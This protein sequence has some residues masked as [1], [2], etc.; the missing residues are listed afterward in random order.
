M[1]TI[2]EFEND[3]TECGSLVSGIA[4]SG[5]IEFISDATVYSTSRSINWI[6]L[7][8][9]LWKSNTT[10]MLNSYHFYDNLVAAIGKTPP[11]SYFIDVLVCT[12]G[13]I[14]TLFALSYSK[15]IDKRV[16]AC[17][18]LPEIEQK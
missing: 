11:S 8:L 3:H 4:I 9:L 1:I 12:V 6:T 17:L 10:D 2:N 14:L 15:Y 7:L 5:F 18:L 16:C 13:I